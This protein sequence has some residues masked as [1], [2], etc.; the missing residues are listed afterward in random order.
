MQWVRINLC[1]TILAILA[2]SSGGAAELK[3]YANVDNSKDI[4]AGE[5]FTYQIII[6]GY[7]QP[8]E[9]DLSPLA[10]FNPR[11]AGG[12]N[13]SQTS[14]SII[15]GRTTRNVVKRYVM[16]YVLTANQRG[17]MR[18][19]AVTVTVEN[20]RYQTNPVEL[21]IIKPG[22]TDQLELEVTLSQEKCYIG[23]PVVL[24]VEFYVYADIGDYS[25]DIPAL[26]N[27]VF[28]VED[29]D[30]GA[31]QGKQS[32][33]VRNNRQAILLTFSKL[34]IPKQAGDFEF[35]PSSVSADVAVG[36][37]RSRDRFFDDFFGRNTR[38]K[39]FATSSKPLKLSVLPLPQENAPEDFY[40]LIG[41]YTISASASP[42]KVS[43][44]DPITL[45]IKIGGDYLKPVQWPRLDQTDSM[46]E[47]FKMPSE[48][49][50]P[51]IENGYKV[52]TQTIRAVNENVTEIPP[53]P[54]AYFDPDKGKFVVTRT[55][56]IPLEVAPTKIL[57]TADIEGMDFK[58]VSREVEAIKK[59][60][61]ANYEGLDCVKNVGFSLSAAALN[62]AYLATWAI[63]LLALL[64]SVI[65]KTF[66]QTTPEQ[67]A[68]KRRKQSAKKAFGLINKISSVQQEKQHELLAEA[69]RQYI[70]DRF[71][72]VAGSLTAD[73]CQQAII[74]CTGD[75]ESAG[76]YRDIISD[77]EA[78]RYA[79]VQT[80]IDRKKIDEVAKLIRTIDK[81][82][83]P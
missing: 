72:K 46:A 79:P 31:G 21:N 53:I 4:Y 20:V 81:K 34:L 16:N 10:G 2:V 1:A 18:I 76:R 35:G 82:S 41:R 69:M 68:R 13:A 64:G 25:F 36:Q 33:V 45:T 12:G 78:A 50:S 24:K 56:P 3:V 17:I 65:L 39:R 5:D 49:A 30:A 9:A 83:K 38:Y 58:P 19:P 7:D 28:G 27:D 51:S 74:T 23:Q 80:Q 67:E 62:P 77:F 75:L 59:G 60:I 48:K 32:R 71:D 43:V 8:G 44:G 14:V 52:F 37:A 11:S 57:T 61:S 42:T 63:P 55:E 66:V 47:N 29:L 15:N 22:T 70:G 54:L 73:D 26:N 40:G 6:D